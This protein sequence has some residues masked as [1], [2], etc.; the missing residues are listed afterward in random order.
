MLYRDDRHQPAISDPGEAFIAAPGHAAATDNTI[1]YPILVLGLGNTLM[2]DDGIGVHVVTRLQ[3]SGDLPDRVSLLDGGTLSFS[4][5]NDI[6]DAA[7]LL[8]VDAARMDLPAG[9]VRCFEGEAM[10]RFLTRNGQ[11]SVHEVS[12]AELLGMA[13]LQDRLPSRRTLVAV[14]PG[15]LGWGSQPS[16]AVHAALPEAAA[17]VR[18]RTEAWLS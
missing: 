5:L 14:Q 15:N 11:C 2:R 13:R 7:A 1:Q 10:D 18:A 3:Q 6:T 4:L 16:P 17:C 9:T 8:V 12:L